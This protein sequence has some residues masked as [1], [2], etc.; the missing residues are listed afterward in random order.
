[1]RVL[2]AGT[3]FKRILELTFKHQIFMIFG[4]ENYFGNGFLKI[5]NFFLK[6]NPLLRM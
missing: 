3:I 2:R 5:V 4:V 6:D 1:M